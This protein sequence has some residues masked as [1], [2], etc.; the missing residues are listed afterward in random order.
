MPKKAAR[1]AE[2]FIRRTSALE[3][4]RAKMEALLTTGALNNADIEHVYAGLFL[5]AFTEFEAL[6]EN[7]FFGLL[8]GKYYC[9]SIPIVRNAK[10]T[11]VAM[12]KQFVFGTK[13]YLDWLP[14]EDHAIP[15]AKL[16]LKNGEPFNS[17]SKPE[18]TSLKNYHLLRNA[19]AH[20]SEVAKKKFEQSI[21][22]FTLLPSEKTPIGFL[23]SKPS[24]LQTQHE[25]TI[26]ELGAIATRLCS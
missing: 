21:G 24:G 18:R 4:T 11:P 6:V 19:V 17:L 2:H 3:T 10:I 7:L 15:R 25:I 1:L 12:T 9:S 14:L 26:L 8:T 5:E 20:K 13:A 22:N 16:Y 23:R